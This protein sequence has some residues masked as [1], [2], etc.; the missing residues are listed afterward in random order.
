MRR[1]V[2]SIIAAVLA[3][4]MCIPGALAAANGV[5]SAE[6]SA[7]KRAKTQLPYEE[8]PM[9]NID[10]TEILVLNIYSGMGSVSFDFQAD[11]G[12]QRLVKLS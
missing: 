4:L 2:F 5:K 12:A 11:D 1:K 7:S 6:D 10:V 8:V 9:E 3:A